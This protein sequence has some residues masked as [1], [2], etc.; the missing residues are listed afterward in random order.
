MLTDKLLVLPYSDRPLILVVEDAPAMNDLLRDILSVDY[1]VDTASNGKEGIEK[2]LLN[3]P[4]LILSDIGMP[5]MNG[6]QMFQELRSIPSLSEIPFMILTAYGDDDNRVMLLRAGV[7]DY[8]AKPFITEE[9]RARIRNLFITIQTRKK[10]ALELEFKK[11]MTA[12]VSHDLKNPLAAMLISAQALSMMNGEDERGTSQIKK[13]AERMIRGV[14]QMERLISSMLDLSNIEAGNFGVT[15]TRQ[16]PESLIEETVSTLRPLAA[17]K[18]IRIEAFT[19]LNH[20]S[21][22]LDKDRL[23]QVFSN[24]VGNAIKFTPDGGTIS[25]KVETAE[26]AMRFSV[27]D[28]GFGMPQEQLAHVFDRY[29]QAKETAHLGTGLG[30]FIVKKIIEAHQGTI[31]VESTLGKGTTF[32]FEL[33]L[34]VE[35]KPGLEISMAP[36]RKRAEFSRTPLNLP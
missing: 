36:A 13:T 21:I 3:K 7:H 25:L 16:H 2:A 14:K 28:T 8:I 19:E 22:D 34:P 1:R 20:P 18:S 31:W 30:L 5:V 12:I 24:L 9:L 35:I 27:S 32:C 29:W 33:P 17:V 4:D 10:L 15:P 6:S 23:I 11:D 26:H